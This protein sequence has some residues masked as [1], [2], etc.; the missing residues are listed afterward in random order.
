LKVDLPWLH[1]PVGLLGPRSARRPGGG[2]ALSFNTDRGM[3]VQNIAGLGHLVLLALL[4][5]LVLVAI[6]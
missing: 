2:R 6:G 3:F 5:L 1:I 4:V